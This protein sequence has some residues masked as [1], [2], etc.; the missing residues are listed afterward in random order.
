VGVFIF[1]GIIYGLSNYIWSIDIETKENLT[2]FEVRRQLDSIGIKPGLKKTDIN[3][4]EIER[5]MQ[6]INNQI[7]WIRTR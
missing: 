3:V 4:Y 6:T 2:P 7:M 1:F 5:K